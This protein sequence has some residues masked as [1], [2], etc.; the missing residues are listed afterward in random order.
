VS[1]AGVPTVDIISSA[2][3]D[4]FTASLDCRVNVSGAWRADDDGAC[5]TVR[6]GIVSAAGPSIGVAAPD[7]HFTP[8]PHHRMPVSARGRVGSA[9]RIPTVG[10]GFVPP[11]GVQI[12]AVVLS[13]PDDH[14]TASPDRP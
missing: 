13:A 4:H 3:D 2:P 1:P 10:V 9:G 5:P 7:N 11:A 8:S 6:A 14:L 12:A